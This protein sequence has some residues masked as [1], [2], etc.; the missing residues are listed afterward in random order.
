[1]NIKSGKTLGFSF[2][3][4]WEF[5][6]EWNRQTGTGL[7]WFIGLI[8]MLIIPLF[9]W[10]VLVGFTWKDELQGFGRWAL[11]AI[12]LLLF[13]AILAFTFYILHSIWAPLSDGF[14][15]TKREMNRRREFEDY[16]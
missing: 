10:T 6:K 15:R 16:R 9:D 12:A 8:I 2:K 7:F 5:L 14:K 11:N 3:G 1:M 4:T 13:N